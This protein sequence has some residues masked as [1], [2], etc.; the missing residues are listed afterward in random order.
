LCIVGSKLA[1]PRKD[2]TAVPHPIEALRAGK[3]PQLQ[4]PIF[5]SD[6]ATQAE[7]SNVGVGRGRGRMVCKLVAVGIS[8]VR[9]PFSLQK[10]Q[11]QHFRH[12]WISAAAPGC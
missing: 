8:E 4:A 2:S 6:R 3:C 12:R 10:L 5:G 1:C 9:S 7:A 11:K